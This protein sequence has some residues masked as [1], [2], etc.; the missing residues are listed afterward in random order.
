MQNRSMVGEII[1]QYAEAFLSAVDHARNCA[2]LD[3]ELQVD[4]FKR[5]PGTRKEETIPPSGDREKN[6][7]DK[8]GGRDNEGRPAQIDEHDKEQ[9]ETVRGLST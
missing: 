4:A 8:K 5:S 3:S 9:E 6:P 7:D 2:K 1:S